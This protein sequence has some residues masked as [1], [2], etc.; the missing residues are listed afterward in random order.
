[1]A[2]LNVWGTDMALVDGSEFC[3]RCEHAYPGHY[4]NCD[5]ESWQYGDAPDCTACSASNAADR[6]SGLCYVC[7]A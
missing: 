2:L 6:V 4:T 5:T 1:M 3:L 7:E